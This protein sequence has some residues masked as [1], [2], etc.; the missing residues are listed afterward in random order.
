MH[1]VRR[2]RAGSR[3]STRTRGCAGT[4]GVEYVR[5]KC[6]RGLRR[7]CIRCGRTFEPFCAL[8][9]RPNSLYCVLCERKNCATRLARARRAECSLP[10]FTASVHCLC[11]L[12]VFT[13]NVHCSC[14]R[15]VFERNVALYFTA[16]STILH[17]QPPHSPHTHSTH[18]P[19]S[20]CRCPTIC[21]CSHT[22]HPHS[23]PHS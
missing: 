23:R 22:H 13:A 11:S 4:N 12:P 21:T 18:T 14:S 20:A 8:H 16:C 3:C 5:S 19:N 17:T 6:S 1:Y 9:E 10:V 7:E 2:A 15:L